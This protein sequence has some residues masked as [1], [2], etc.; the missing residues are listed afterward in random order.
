M[1]ISDVPEKPR[2]ARADGESDTPALT[3]DPALA[4]ISAAELTPK[5]REALS[6]LLNEIQ[7]LRNNL[8]IARE[9]AFDLEQLADRD[10]LL[11]ILNR[12]AFARELDRTV[13]MADRYE[14]PASLVFLDLNGLKTINDMRGHSAGDAALKHVADVLVAHSRQTDIVGRLGGDEFGLLL[15]HADKSIALSKA[16]ELVSWVAKTPVRWNGE[17]FPVSVSIGVSEILKGGSADQAMEQAD[18]AMYKAKRS[19]LVTR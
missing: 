2:T 10:P 9:R 17:E 7:T 14:T 19:G 18:S 1:K 12:R 15:T 13:S 16:D 3:A 6:G 8:A 5:V 11:D 4:G